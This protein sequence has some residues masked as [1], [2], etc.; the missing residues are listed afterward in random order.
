MWIIF[1]GILA[2]LLQKVGPIV[3][4]GI[5]HQFDSILLRFYVVRI[6]PKNVFNVIFFVTA[7]LSHVPKNCWLQLQA[8][9]DFGILFWQGWHSSPLFSISI[10]HSFSETFL[11]AFSTDFVAKMLSK[12]PPSWHQ[13]LQKSDFYGNCPVEVFF[14]GFGVLLTAFGS[15]LAIPGHHFELVCQLLLSL[16]VVIVIVCL[17]VCCYWFLLFVLLCVC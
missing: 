11:D 13:H 2:W 4:F 14:I 1:G 17:V 9:F 15:P 3:A 16:F 6:V 12:R 8:S 7:E 5:W 10:Q